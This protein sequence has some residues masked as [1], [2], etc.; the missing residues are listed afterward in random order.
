M[1]PDDTNGRISF[2]AK[3]LLSSMDTKLDRIEEALGRK[4]DRAMAE[5]MS[6]R[7]NA[8]EARIPI[9]EKL[10]SEFYE[11]QRR[12]AHLESIVVGREGYQRLDDRVQTLERTAATQTGL[13][14][15]RK[16]LVALAI[17]SVLSLVGLVVTIAFL[18]QH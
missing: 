15:Y 8:L 10:I 9:S 3:E 6:S 17:P 7:V 2:T 1:T 18:F 11:V 16:W 12:T 4:V 5:S 14:S 13:S